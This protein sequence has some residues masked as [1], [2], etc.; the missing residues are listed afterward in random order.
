MRVLHSNQKL[1]FIV[2]GL[3]STAVH[4]VVFTLCYKVFNLG[5]VASTI[6]GFMTS[7]VVAYCLNYWIT[8][9]SKRIHTSSFPRYLATT[10]IGLAWNIGLMLFF[11]EYMAFHYA[12]AFVCMS[13]VVMVNNYVLSKFWAFA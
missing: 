9:K 8:F 10:L 12:F 1:R 11:V 6:F 4:F 7:L 5:I 13:A 3:I 2:V